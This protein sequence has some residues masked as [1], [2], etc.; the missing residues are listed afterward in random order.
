MYVGAERIIK[1]KYSGTNWGMMRDGQSV[2]NSLPPRLCTMSREEFYPYRPEDESLL[3]PEK[4][5]INTLPRLGGT[6]P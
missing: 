2:H 5:H 3:E 4:T 1:N 6:N